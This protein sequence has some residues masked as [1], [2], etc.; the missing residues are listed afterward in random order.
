MRVS[1]RAGLVASAALGLMATFM[2]GAQATTGYDRCP[3]G[4]LCLFDG[5]HGSGTMTIYSGSTPALGAMDRRASSMA[6]NTSFPYLCLFSEPDY[7][8]WDLQ[9]V[10]ET[11][12]FN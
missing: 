8:G 2:T 3:K 10:G 9:V 5:T 7:Q 4:K 12:P 11:P 6:D 1:V